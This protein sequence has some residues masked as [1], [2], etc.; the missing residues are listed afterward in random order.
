MSTKRKISN[1]TKIGREIEE[2]I[3]KKICIS[4]KIAMIDKF[5]KGLESLNMSPNE[6]KIVLHLFKKLNG[7]PRIELIDR[8]IMFNEFAN[9]L[10]INLIKWP[11]IFIFN[12]VEYISRA[13]KLKIRHIYLDL[14][15]T[16]ILYHPKL[17][18][19]LLSS[20]EY[21]N[22]ETMNII[23]ADVEID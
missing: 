12:T 5:I 20:Y 6:L 2:T 13:R 1:L 3:S 8:L 10:N 7:K 22:I 17:P 14:N 16:C 21:I 18:L 19:G 4:E 9:K 23:L 15:G 11:E